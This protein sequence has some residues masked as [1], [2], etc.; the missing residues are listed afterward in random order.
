[1]KLNLKTI[2]LGGAAAL[3]LLAAPLAANRIA[4]A[5]GGGCGDRFEALNLTESQTTQIEAIREDARAAVQAVL[6]DDQRAAL[7]DAEGRE[8][9][10]VWRSLDL[11]DEQREQI[12][13]IK[14]DSREEVQ[15][16]LTDEQRQQLEE[17]RQN[18]RGARRG[19]RQEARQGQEL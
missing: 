6:T 16:V 12:R 2:A 10:G 14:E 11:S 7:D 18:R 5:A 15:A 4:Y 3:T 13:A 19:A 1:M 8:K 17:L 9:R